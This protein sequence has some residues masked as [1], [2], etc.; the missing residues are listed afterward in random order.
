[1]KKILFLFVSSLILMSCD[2]GEGDQQNFF[3]E[4]MPIQS[5]EIPSEFTFGETYE[6]S[7]SYMAP[8][9]C[10]EFNDLFFQHN[11]DNEQVISVINTV[12]TDQVCNFVDEA[13]VVPFDFTI[14]SMDTY[15][16][17]FWQGKD[18]TGNDIFLIVEVPVVE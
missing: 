3:F 16:F 18:N 15:I 6:L 10:Y 11:I 12:Y 17:K 13:E 2:I 1:M 14:N 8:N 5:V 7:V 9:D 4:I